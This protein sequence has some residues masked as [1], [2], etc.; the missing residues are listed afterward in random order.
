MTEKK[1]NS[2]DTQAWQ[3]SR[4][5]V[6]HVG[7]VLTSFQ[8]TIR[9]LLI[10]ERSNPPVV[11]P[12]SHFLVTRFLRGRTMKALFYYATLTFHGEEVAN[13]PH[14]SS[15]QLIRFFSPGELAAM[16]AAI[17]AYRRIKGQAPPEQWNEISEQMILEADIGMHTGMAI[18]AIG[19]MVGMLAGLMPRLSRGLFL[20][21]DPDLFSEYWRRINLED[22]CAAEELELE[23]WGCTSRHIGCSLLQGLGLSVPMAHG[24]YVGLS[25]RP[26]SDDKEE[27]LGYAFAIA[28]EW[29][30][31]LHENGAPPERVHMGK[32][33]PLQTALHKLLYRVNRLRE[34]GNGYRWLERSK[35]DISVEK[36]PQLFQEALMEGQ[37]PGALKEFYKQ[38]LPQ[39]VLQ[40]LSEEELSNISSNEEEM[41]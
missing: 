33:Y 31:G 5:Y 36:T 32:Y 8:T 4:V 24:L 10:D 2:D 29:I 41:D 7:K 30:K 35:D 16:I 12:A 38:H 27:R 25:S 9:T 3:K 26:P 14:L 34:H 20:V 22:L 23:L 21:E 40:T 13:T 39:E 6:D 37:N 1:E 18:P 11:S 19:G 28:R 17:Y 15:S